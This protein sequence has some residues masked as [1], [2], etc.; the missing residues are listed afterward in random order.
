MNQKL[1]AGVNKVLVC[2]FAKYFYDFRLIIVQ[3]AGE[4][5][6]ICSNSIFRHL[7]CM[8]LVCMPSSSTQFVYSVHLEV[9]LA[10]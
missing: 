1:H 9:V 10:C 3:C 6:L 7:S 2:D 5:Y 4:T 8:H